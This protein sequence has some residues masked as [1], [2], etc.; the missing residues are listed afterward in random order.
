MIEL[1][2]QTFEL[3]PVG[4]VDSNLRPRSTLNLST[5]KPQCVS[6]Y[7]L[8]C[9]GRPIWAN[10]KKPIRDRTML[11]EDRRATQVHTCNCAIPT[12]QIRRPIQWPASSNRSP[13]RNSQSSS[14]PSRKAK[15]LLSW[16]QN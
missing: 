7:A 10:C 14:Q 4:G 11:T 6:T 15:T 1:L 2:K 5:A 13:G 16:L 9:S 3:L 8:G 12:Q